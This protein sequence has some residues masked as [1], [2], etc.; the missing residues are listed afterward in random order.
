MARRLWR[1][2]TTG[3]LLVDSQGRPLFCDLCPCRD[4]PSACPGC[5]S[6]PTPLQ[7]SVELTGMTAGLLGCADCAQLDYTDVIFSTILPAL[8]ADGNVVFGTDCVWDQPERFEC[9]AEPCNVLTTCAGLAGRSRRWL[10]ID[11]FAPP[12][13]AQGIGVYLQHFRSYY[14]FGPTLGG[15]Y[16]RWYRPRMN[17]SGPTVFGPGD[18]VESL[19][20][21]IAPFCSYAAATAT[22]TPA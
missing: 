11:Y 12:A 5:G 13:P 20:T 22:V 8:D 7:L 6:D 9:Y 19:S 4:I 3:R 15:A 21:E 1:D 14:T 16:A 10:L 17:C 18:L 2:T